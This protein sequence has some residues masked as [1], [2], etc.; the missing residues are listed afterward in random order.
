MVMTPG[1]VGEFL[2]S[3]MVRQVGGAPMAQTAP[4]IVAERMTDGFAMLVLACL[5]L[6]TYPSPALQA[7][8]LATLA[9]LAAV[10][11][12]VQLRPLA[13]RLLAWC[14]RLPVVGPHALHFERFYESSYVLLKPRNLLPA[15]AIGVVSWACEGLAYYVVLVGFGAPPGATTAWQAIFIFSISSILG[16]LVATPGGLGATEASLVALS[17]ATFGLDRTAAT[18]A[19][20]LIRLC[21]LW[22]GVAIGLA[23]LARWPDLLAGAP[24]AAPAGEP[25]EPGA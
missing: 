12:V 20:L 15:V 24:D 16:A 19:A 2:K 11:V 23:C 9:A 10:V 13:R 14:E 3:Y 18:A 4:I 6:W 7:A 17:Q 21:T 25:A 1:K 8:A 5:G 22:F